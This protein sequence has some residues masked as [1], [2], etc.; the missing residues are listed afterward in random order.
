[1]SRQVRGR[2]I[3]A[4]AAVA[5]LAWTAAAGAASAPI[6]DAA[7]LVLG[8]SDFAGGAKVDVQKRSGG[9]TQPA[10]LRSFRPGARLGSRPLLSAVDVATV[11]PTVDEA[12]GDL[13]RTRAA[14]RSKPI[15]GAI[16]TDLGRT[17]AKSSK[18]KLKKTVAGPPI[19]FGSGAFEV[20][21]T[22]ELAGGSIRMAL[23]FVQ[24]ERA[25][26]QIVLFYAPGARIPRPDVARAVRAVQGHIRTAFTTANTAAPTIGGTP[27]QGAALTVD[28]G[29]WTG[30]PSGYTY[31]WSRCDAAGAGCTPIPDATA[32]TYAVAPADA[33]LTLRV[34]VTGSNGLGEAQATSAQTAVVQ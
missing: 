31:A 25:S 15:R 6:P 21:V 20:P 1:V 13:A 19:A 23:V 12:A 16:A 30:A 10:Y 32:A 11:H 22:F 34:T 28:E 3:V 17:F 9:A 26:E 24:L 2:A 14:M 33:G 8:V 5:A 4:A 18:L 27:A 7:G 29:D